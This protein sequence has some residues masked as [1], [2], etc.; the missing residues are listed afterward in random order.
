MMNNAQPARDNGFE[1]VLAGAR[2][3]EANFDRFLADAGRGKVDAKLQASLCSQILLITNEATHAL[4]RGCEG[5]P[6]ASQAMTISIV[7]GIPRQFKGA[8]EN[9]LFRARCQMLSDEQARTTKDLYLVSARVILTAN[10]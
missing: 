1:A 4:E 3:F 9:A 2:A 6:N 7:R 8:L 5:K 10:A